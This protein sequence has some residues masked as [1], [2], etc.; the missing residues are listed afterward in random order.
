M[1]DLE[2]LIIL[3]RVE[4]FGA[5]TLENLLRFF[6][7]PKDILKNAGALSKTALISQK[8]AG[9]ISKAKKEADLSREFKAIKKE[10]ARL[11]TI[12]E[13]AYPVS[14]KN[15]FSPPILLYVKGNLKPEDSLSIAI[16]GSRIPTWYGKHT[17]ERLASRLASRG[18]TV[19]S[20]MA[21][22]IDSASHQG[23]LK[24]GGRTIAVLGSGI[25]IMYPAENRGLAGQIEVSGAVISEF[26]A[27][28][29]PLR[30]NFPRRNRIISGLSLGVIV[31]EAAEKS[32]SLITADF[33]LEQGREVFAV[34]GKI[35]SRTSR[36]THNLIK[37]GA[38]LASSSED[39]IE[40]LAPVLKNYARDA[41]PK[42]IKPALAGLE[43]RIC[44]ILSSEP[45]HIDQIIKELNLS[46]GQT[47]SILL[48]LQIKKLVKELPGKYFV[49][50]GD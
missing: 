26:P 5:S 30:R 46:A 11:I 3:N 18:M 48:K 8:I 44:S 33:A 40:E 19:V 25:D 24:A 41:K 21:R 4:G 16:V 12:F 39:I 13:E 45:R 17:A 10:Q 49:G 23:A 9:K 38:K 7:S 34:P 20:G 1:N 14:L 50:Y 47:L 32:G 28:T 31:V 2:S 6:K 35:D 29:P 37:Q 27:G 15:I 22:G 43:K 36:G 42:S